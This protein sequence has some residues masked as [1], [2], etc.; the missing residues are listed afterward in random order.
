MDDPLLAGGLAVAAM[1]MLAVVGVPVGI[2]MGAVAIVGLWL[3]GGAS[4]A[5]SV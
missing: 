5:F 3:T 1:L 4:F 2:A